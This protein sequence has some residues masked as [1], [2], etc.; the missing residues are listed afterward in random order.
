MLVTN[1]VRAEGQVLLVDSLSHENTDDV[2][3]FLRVS[4]YSYSNL[5]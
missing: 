2:L 5:A 4:L 1:L 3:P